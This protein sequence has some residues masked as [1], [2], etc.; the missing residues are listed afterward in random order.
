MCHFKQ[1]NLVDYGHQQTQ[2]PISL[3]YGWKR[4]IKPE[5]KMNNKWYNGLKN[6]LEPFIRYSNNNDT[7]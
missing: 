6:P 2:G 1:S 7:N 5:T 4:F 3:G